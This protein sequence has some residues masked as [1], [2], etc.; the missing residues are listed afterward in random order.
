MQVSVTEVFIYFGIF[1]GF[2]MTL[3]IM[4]KMKGNKQIK[5]SLSLYLFFGVLS[6]LIGDL[7]FSEKAL[8]FP[9]LMRLD[10][11]L[12]FLYGP[13][14]FYY[15][16]ASLKP[17]FRFRKI[18]LLHLV[19]F[20]INFVIFSPLYFSSR[21]FKLE[22]YQEILETGT[23]TLMRFYLLKFVSGAVYLILQVS[24]FLKFKSR[25]QSE[26]QP[27]GILVKWFRIY[28]FIQALMLLTIIINQFLP[29]S[30]M[31]DPYR[32]FMIMLTV[33]IIS[34]SIALMFFP[35]LLYGIQATFQKQRMKYYS[36]GLKQEDVDVIYHKLLDY[37]S[38]NDKPYTNPDLSLPVTARALNLNANQLSR[39]I[40]EKS[41]NNFKDYIN[42]F[43]IEEA[44]RILVSEEYK[45]LT[46]DAI[47]IK[48]GFK[49]RTPFYKAFKEHTG[50][51]PKKY[52]VNVVN[53]F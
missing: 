34:T 49:S 36:S 51:T 11:P 53:G 24:F 40:N 14:A 15:T 42:S 33:L 38:N 37:L 35:A 5:I 48:A 41:G 46:I 22:Y 23:Y 12:H 50:M 18:Y 25:I 21:D 29:D 2:I 44:K 45:K 28:F 20:L 8:K 9:Y 27:N 47:A 6:L 19:P 10:S 17:E 31:D 32:L 26:S 1:L 16:Y 13:F 4:T 39:V 30:L 3:V 52:V 43:R 7:N